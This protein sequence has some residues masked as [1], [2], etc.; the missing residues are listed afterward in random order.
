MAYEISLKGKKALITGASR[1]I[2]RAI[3]IG[4][5]E[6]GADVA[7]TSRTKT[8]L[9]EATREIEKKGVKV[10]PILCDLAN[11]Q[12][13]KELISQVEEKCQV[14]DILVNSAGINIPS[15]M[16]EVKEEDWDM[17]I[18]V[19]LKAP[20]LLGQAFGRLMIEKKVKGSII[21]ITSECQDLA[22]VD[23]GAYNPSKGALKMLTR[24]MAAEWGEF[25]IR[26]N[27][28]APSFVN[29]KIN[30]TI[31]P[32]SKDSPT[33]GLTH[34]YEKKLARVPL[35]RHAEPEDLVGAAVY[36]ASDVSSYVTG[37]TLLV[38]GGYTTQ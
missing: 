22:E 20:F 5:A 29:T 18:N 23:F 1:G 33:D 14:I 19:N 10:F 30:E 2:G 16:E 3:A 35:Q 21:N 26:A 34:F 36:L 12:E 6:A 24:T 27:N 4:F 25:G 7:I 11:T 31:F 8:D 13:I 17:V 9:M 37:T 28:L 15:P 38:D 32:G